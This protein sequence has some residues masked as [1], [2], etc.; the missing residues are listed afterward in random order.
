MIISL[1]F[2]GVIYRMLTFELNRVERMHRLRI[3]SGYPQRPPPFL[4]DPDLIAE[5]KNRIKTTLAIINFGI[6]GASAL[7]GYFLA[8]RTL[9]PIQEMLEEQK[10]FVAD[11]SHEL[12][13]PLTALKSE[14]EVNLRHKKLTLP[15]A[16]KLIASNLEEVNKM[17]LL[18]EKLLCLSR[19]QNGVSTTAKVNLKEVMEKAVLKLNS[20]AK[21][22]KMVVIKELKNVYIKGDLSSL[23]DLATILIDNAIKYSRPKGKIILTTQKQDRQVIIKVQDFGVGIEASALPHLFKRFYRADSSR[24]KEIDGYGLGLSIA[25]KICDLHRGKITVSSTPGKGSTFLVQLPFFSAN[26]QI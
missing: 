2:S 8:G 14:I 20:L 23:T 12:R 6:L 25:K 9:Q 16:K 24:S 26:S 10:R 18:T 1:A 11:A 15:E 7:A 17:Q 5:T 21:D 19:Y 13:T 3:E 22:K 4:L